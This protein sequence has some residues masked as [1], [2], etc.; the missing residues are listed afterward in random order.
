MYL[1]LYVHLIL[2]LFAKQIMMS[3]YIYI[4]KKSLIVKI[5]GIY[6]KRFFLAF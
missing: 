1:S 6:T 5:P 3:K 2:K 4:F